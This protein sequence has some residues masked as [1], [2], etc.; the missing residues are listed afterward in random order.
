LKGRGRERKGS[1]G[2]GEEGVVLQVSAR[3]AVVLAREGPVRCTYRSGLFLDRDRFNRPVAAGD[4]VRISRPERSEPM[5]E[6]VLPR[7][8][9]I[10]R[11]R[12]GPGN[13][14]IIVANPSRVLAIGSAAEPDFRPRLIDRILTTAER[15]QVPAVVVINKIDLAGERA[16]FEEWAELYR[17]IGYRAVLASA[18]TGEGIDEIRAEIGSGITV[19]AGQS[20][21]GKSSL[22]S[23][24]APGLDLLSAP[25]TQ[26]TGKGQHTT[27][28][29][30]LHPFGEGAFLADSPG[31]RS[32]ALAEPVG[33]DLSLRFREM[34]PFIDGCRFRDCLH[35]DEPECAVRAALD[36]GEIDPRRYAS[37]ERIVRGDESDVPEEG[38]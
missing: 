33:P 38:E 6:D 11:S 28:K 12:R 18:R 17:R 27:T 15:A 9:W 3:H 14:Q 22:L 7:S 8:T 24:V 5:I 32:F 30:T 20:G 34:L 2:P 16:P 19:V 21:V 25:V 10:S 36:R 1:A 23:A 35:L 4:R 31:V 37:Y 26:S 29:V 13:E